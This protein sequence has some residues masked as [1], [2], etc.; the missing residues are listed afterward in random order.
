MGTKQTFLS[1]DDLD[2]QNQEIKRLKAKLEDK[3]NLRREL[4]IRDDSAVKFY[5]GI[6]S[7]TLLIAIFSILK[8]AAEKMKYWVRG[9]SN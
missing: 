7:L 4:F 9:E 8:P 3:E 6:P 5:T 1:S 2:E